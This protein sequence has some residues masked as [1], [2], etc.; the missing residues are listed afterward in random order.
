[1][2]AAV[3]LPC[4]RLIRSAIGPYNLHGLAPGLHEWTEEIVG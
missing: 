2:T 1:M 3:G 4:L